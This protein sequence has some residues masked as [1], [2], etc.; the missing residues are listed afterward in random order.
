MS[1]CVCVCSAI[2]RPVAAG[3]LD[4][5]PGHS[6]EGSGNLTDRATQAGDTCSSPPFARDCFPEL[7][8][9]RPGAAD[10]R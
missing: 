7:V 3:P 5:G 8:W 6:P 10:T 1:V 2:S 9:A 4:S